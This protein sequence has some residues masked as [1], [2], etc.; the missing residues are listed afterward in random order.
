[1][2]KFNVFLAKK[3]IDTVY[4]SDSCNAEYV[5]DSLIGH[6]CYDPRVTV[7]EVKPKAVPAQEVAL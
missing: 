3:L 5:K 2:R 6:D 1:M 4:F 7:R